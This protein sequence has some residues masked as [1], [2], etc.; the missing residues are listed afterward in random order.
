MVATTMPNLNNLI[1]KISA[2]YPDISIQAGDCA[3]FSPP[4]TIFY[5]QD[6]TPLELL[7]ELGHALLGKTNYTSDIELVRIESEAWQK[8][9][10]LCS[11]YQVKWDKEI[12][13]DHIDTYRDWLHT[14]SLCHNCQ[15]TGYQDNTGTYHC[16]FCGSSWQNDIL[17]KDF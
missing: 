8:A 4:S 12:A 15:L 7:H 10:D 2:D 3:K 1:A 5:S 13:E 14:V 11:T 17:P 16:S 6:T 9:K